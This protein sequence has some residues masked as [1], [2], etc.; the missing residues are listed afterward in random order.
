M[1]VNPFFFSSYVAPA[2]T[3]RV[4]KT[5]PNHAKRKFGKKRVNLFLA[6]FEPTTHQST[7]QVHHQLNQ[8]IFVI[9]SIILGFYYHV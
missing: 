8:F 9:I 3:A 5:L 2:S 1:D 7:S 6:R 4:S